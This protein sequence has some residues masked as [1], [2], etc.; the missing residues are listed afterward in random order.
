M[1]NAMLQVVANLVLAPLRKK[2]VG[3]QPLLA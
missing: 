3:V 1:R 2:T